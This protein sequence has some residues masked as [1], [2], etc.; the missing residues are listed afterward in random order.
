M[1]TLSTIFTSNLHKIMKT[2]SFQKIRCVQILFLS[3]NRYIATTFIIR[4]RFL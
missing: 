4:E 3:K 1:N 2:V